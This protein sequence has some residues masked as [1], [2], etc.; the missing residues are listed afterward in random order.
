[1]FEQRFGHKELYEVVIRAKTPMDFGS[2]H[3]V[4]DEPLLY[5]SNVNMSLLTE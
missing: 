2:R 5:F 4:T 3:L 1:M